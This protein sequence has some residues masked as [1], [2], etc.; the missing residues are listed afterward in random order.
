[1]P[2]AGHDNLYSDRRFGLRS[3]VNL[4]THNRHVHTRGTHFHAYGNFNGNC[5]PHSHSYGNRHGGDGHSDSD[6]DANSG[7]N[8]EYGDRHAGDLVAFHSPDSRSTKSGC[9]P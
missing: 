7:D 5:D 1:M 4:A 3:F 8:P 6:R 9:V 2:S